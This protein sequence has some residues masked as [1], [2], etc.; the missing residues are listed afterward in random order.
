[1]Q[2]IEGVATKKGDKL[3]DR[4]IRSLTP[5]STDKIYEKI[6]VGP[7]GEMLTASREGRGIVPACL[8]RRPPIVSYRI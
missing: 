4:H 2:L 8:A 7:D 5:I 6:L 1:M 3:G